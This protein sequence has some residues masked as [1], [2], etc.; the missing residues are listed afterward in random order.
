LE[1]TNNFKYE[2]VPDVSH[3]MGQAGYR[4]G[5]MEILAEPVY[6][7]GGGPASENKE[8]P[9]IPESFLYTEKDING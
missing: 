4:M 5:L 9:F 3:I 7:K 8:P 2:Y 1:K 6:R